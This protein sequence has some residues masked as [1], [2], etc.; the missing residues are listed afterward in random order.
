MILLDDSVLADWSSGAEKLLE[1]GQ[2]LKTANKSQLWKKIDA[3]GF[4][5]WADLESFKW[6]GT[7]YQTLRRIDEVVISII[8]T[9]DPKSSSGK[10]R[11]VQKFMDDRNFKDYFTSP[12]QEILANGFNAL[13]SDNEKAVDTFTRSRGNGILFPQEW[14]RLRSRA[15]DPIEY[16]MEQL[17]LLYPANRFETPEPEEDWEYPQ[18]EI[19]N[20]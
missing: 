15:G 16:V 19:D 13:I 6:S 10:L 14:N 11:W 3:E 17:K 4:K 18:E 8:P 5:F 20:V 9:S 7:F 1:P 12:R 2:T